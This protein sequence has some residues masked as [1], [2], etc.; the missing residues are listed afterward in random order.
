MKR[1]ALVP[2]LLIIALAGFSTGARA[3]AV[4]VVVTGTYSSTAASTA[5]SGPGATFSISFALPVNIGPTLTVAGVSLAVTFNSTTTEIP[6]A[7]V[8]LFPAPIGGGFDIDI[9]YF[10]GSAY[11]WDFLGT[12][13]Y[14]SADN[15]LIG[16]FPISPTSGSFASELRVNG[17][18]ALISGGTV[19]TSTSTGISTTPEP[20]SL[21]LLGT[22]LLGLGIGIR[23]HHRSTQAS[24]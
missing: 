21:L 14:D 12:Q 15:L 23:R 4:N 7:V 2:A 9:A 17:A 13:L 16:T 20:G 19:T 18:V 10:S 3:S 24:R 1:F 22:G 8:T 11:E 5:F 6:G